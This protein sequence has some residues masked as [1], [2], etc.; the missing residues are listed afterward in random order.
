VTARLTAVLIAATATCCAAGET[1]VDLRH[2]ARLGPEGAPLEV[3]VF[4]DFQCPFCRRAAVELK[5][6][7][8]ARPGRVKIYFKHFPLEYHAQAANAA[9]AAEAARLQGRFWEMHDLLFEYSRELH[10]GIYEAMA[11]E[12]G[13]DV[14][15]FGEDM[16]SFEVANRIA[17]DI[18][19]GDA[20]GVDGVPHFLLN[21]IP[22]RGSYADLVEELESYGG[23][24]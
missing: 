17:A 6:I 23:S 22:F 18:D 24:W 12:I 19:E 20:I 16:G 9:R 15:R 1:S 2:A 14:A 8:T 13:L 21:R 4:S 7:H 11:A 3:V 5:R 10:D